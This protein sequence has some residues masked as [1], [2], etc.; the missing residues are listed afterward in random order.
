[1]T[2]VISPV[3]SLPGTAQ[4]V[5]DHARVVLRRGIGDFGYGWGLAPWYV[6][7]RGNRESDEGGVYSR[8]PRLPRDAYLVEAAHGHRDQWLSDRLNARGLPHLPETERRTGHVIRPS[9]PGPFDE[10]DPA[11]G[12]VWQLPVASLE[13]ARDLVAGVL[14]IQLRASFGEEDDGKW[15]GRGGTGAGL[16]VHVNR[17]RY[18][19]HVP[20]DDMPPD[21][22]FARV[23][24]PH[25]LRDHTT[26]LLGAGFQLVEGS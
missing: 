22:I 19:R 12:G 13:A 4:L 24:D 3:G 10:G 23:N 6:T 11:L 8:E 20:Y 7:V 9:S 5:A 26:Q 15:I 1:M 14:T 17:L 2:R 21:A 16:G 25:G 18:D